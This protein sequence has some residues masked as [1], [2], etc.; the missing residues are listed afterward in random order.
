[1][2]DL[3]T[4]MK[5]NQTQPLSGSSLASTSKELNIPHFYQQLFSE[6]KN[7]E[8]ESEPFERDMRTIL[9]DHFLPCECD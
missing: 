6:W 2:A 9:L 4:K 3:N 7:S 5:T 8:T 1:M